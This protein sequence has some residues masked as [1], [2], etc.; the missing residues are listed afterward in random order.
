[1]TYIPDAQVFRLLFI[2]F[3]GVLCLS[4]L[5]F[6]RGAAPHHF[7]P[8]FPS[9]L[10]LCIVYCVLRL[11]ARFEPAMKLVSYKVIDFL[12]LMGYYYYYQ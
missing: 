3:S 6:I 1:M 9:E 12:G 7:T 5:Y 10:R 2:L 8:E 11:M 4:L